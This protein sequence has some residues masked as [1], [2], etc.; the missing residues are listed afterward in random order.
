M[1]EPS[2][3][4]GVPNFNYF[5]VEK[6]HPNA[7]GVGERNWPTKFVYSITLATTPAPTVLPPSLI[8]NRRPSAMGTGKI[9]EISR[10]ALSPGTT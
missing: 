5:F 1:G 9:R 10:V 3:Q 4:A 2:P 8:A 6:R 7:K